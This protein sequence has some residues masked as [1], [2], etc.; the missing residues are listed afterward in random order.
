[1]RERVPGLLVAAAILSAGCMLA[2]GSGPGGLSGWDC[3]NI[4]GGACQEE[5]QRLA[6]AHPGATAISLTCGVPQCIRAGGAGSAV[7]TLGNGAQV[8]EAWSYTGDPGPLPNPACM[9]IPIALCRRQATTSAE[10]QPF[11]KRIVA[12]AI[13]CTAAA[14]TEQAG[15]AA[16]T[17]SF[18]DGSQSSV[19]TGWNGPQP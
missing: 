1:M 10:D 4:P 11:S 6:V 19:G 7:I 3:T 15:E 9:G 17:F 18:A 12:I 8:T 5:A 2:P 14:C 13:R 16:V